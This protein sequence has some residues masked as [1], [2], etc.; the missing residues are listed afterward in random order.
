M[1]KIFLVLFSIV[2][3]FACDNDFE[4][5]NNEPTSGVLVQVS[6]IDALLQGIYDGYFPIGDLKEYGNYGIGTFNGLDGE[7]IVFNDTVFQVVAS[8]DVKRP[9]DDVLTP[10][11]AVTMMHADTT[12]MLSATS[13][14]E[15]KLNFD[16]YFPTPNLFYAVKIK[17]DF[18]YLKTRSVPKQTKPYPPL[19]EVTA[20]QPEFEF[21]N[22]SGD[23]IGLYCPEYAKGINVTGLH[24]H[25]LNS[26]RTGGGHILEFSLKQGSM[27][28][29]YLM[30][31]RL[32]LPEGGDFY[33]GD[34]TVDRTDDLEEA[35]N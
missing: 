10:F 23:I 25:F 29:G 16:S 6:V 13:F 28:I 1:K 20:N 33:G 27:E 32:I 31:Y 15:I 22:E 2:F 34:F 17:G 35:E 18:K 9:L 8:G 7:M 24:L 4:H 5:E 21:E 14:E 26:S 3:L 19:V 11:A 30:D 12:F